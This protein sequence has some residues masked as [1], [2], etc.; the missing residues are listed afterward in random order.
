MIATFLLAAA[1]AM[2]FTADQIAAD[3]VTHAL[4]A[5]GH[6]V[7]TAGPVTFRGECMERDPA[8]TLLF[9]DPVCVTTC[10]NAVGHTH[11]NVSG[12]VEYKQDDYVILR[13]AWLRF[14]EVPVLWLPYMYYPLLDDWG[15][16]WMPGYMGRWG[17][18]LL[19]RYSYHLLGD[20]D[21]GRDTYWLKGA[22]RFDLR[23][24]QGIAL[25]EELDWN[26]GDFGRGEFNIYYAWDQDT[27][28]YDG[29]HE[30][31]YSSSYHSLNWETP[32]DTDRYRIGFKHQ[33]DPTERDTVRLRAN[34][35]T[36]SSFREDFERSTLFGSRGH[37]TGYQNSGVF[38]EH[39]ENSIAIGAEASARLND[40]YEMTDR[41]PEIYLDVNPLPVFDLP[42][43]YE[44]E[45]RIGYLRR[46]PAEYGTGDPSSVYT[47]SPGRWA[48]YDAFRI[49]TYHRLTAPFKTF[50]DILSVVPRIGYHGTYWS[51]SGEDNLSG[52][53]RAVNDGNLVRSI[54]EGGVTF[55]ARGSGMVDERWRHVIEPYFDVLAQKAWYAGSGRPYVFD[56]IDASVMWEDQFAGRARNLPYSYYGVTPGLRNAW[57]AM[58]E[59]GNFR[60]IFDFDVYAALQF[61]ETDYIG[62]NDK[63]K[64]AEVGDPNY[65]KHNGLIVPGARVRWNPDKDISLMGRVEYDSDN[66]RVAVAD[67]GWRQKVREHFSYNVS[68][69]LR[70]FRCWDFSSAPYHPEQMTCDG[71]NDA[72]MHFI[73]VGFEN[74]PIDWFAWG[75]FVRWDLRERELDRIGTWFDFLT[76]CLG[77]RFIVEYENSYER[78][79]GYER[80]DDWS[81]GFY[82]Y[83]RAFGSGSDAQSILGGR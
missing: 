26:L 46:N 27:D 2:T 65:G 19:T 32:V 37:W 58:N 66:N 14:C 53:G 9:H 49:D 69:A 78:I 59:R 50:D 39:V 12:E 33:L 76:D 75:P 23:S 42:V 79:D 36:D 83:L 80:K 31:D 57:E 30:H 29:H 60:E 18:Y 62:G 73:N 77:F 40:F 64:L 45:N 34:Y 28:R 25:G 38:W 16:R 1:G 81:F 41:L 21:H 55:A 63:H 13:N 35:Y 7:A 43:N 68:Y 24:R 70:D 74:Q 17:A 15:F 3:N 54:L 72:K 56:S 51:E 61:N 52:W 8:G 4:T 47:F 67:A 6:I 82:I 11:W 48:E 10:S 22:T 20:P 5:T 44:T 71:F